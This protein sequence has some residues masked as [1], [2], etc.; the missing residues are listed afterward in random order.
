MLLLAAKA[1]AVVL[2]LREGG[3]PAQPQSQAL[4]AGATLPRPAV[5]QHRCHY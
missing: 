4:H 1:K 3:S 2:G 5:V